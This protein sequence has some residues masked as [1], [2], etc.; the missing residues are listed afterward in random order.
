MPPPFLLGTALCLCAAALGCEDAAMSPAPLAV[1]RPPGAQD[2]VSDLDLGRMNQL[3]LHI[4]GGAAPPEMFGVYTLD[5]GRYV[6]ATDPREVGQ[7]TCHSRATYA[8]G[9]QGTVDLFYE[10]LDCAGGGAEQR[11][12]IS[13]EGPC[14]TLYGRGVQLVDGCPMTFV[15]VSSACLTPGGLADFQEGFLYEAM[16]SASCA[17]LVATGR[18]PRLGNIAV[19]AETDGLA[20]RLR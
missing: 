5:S 2:A 8:A 11:M 10:Y 3:G 4:H 16:D 15:T 18:A 7:A 20:A 17:G 12:F 14:F 6:A 1:V 9:D 13:G 19:V